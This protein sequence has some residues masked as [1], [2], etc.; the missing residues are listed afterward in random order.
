M[1][2]S[3]KREAPTQSAFLI[4]KYGCATPAIQNLNQTDPLPG[5]P[6]ECFA[7]TEDE[8]AARMVDYLEKRFGQRT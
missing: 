3:L 6:V 1:S 4:G 2:R 5:V 7:S 8:A